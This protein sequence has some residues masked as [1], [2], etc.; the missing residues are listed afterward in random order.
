MKDKKP[1]I[2][3]SEPVREIISN[4]PRRIIRW[5]TTFIFSVLALLLILSWL[6]KYPDVVPATIEITTINPPVTLVS[7]ITGRIN[8]LYVKDEQNVSSGQLLAVMETAASIVEVRQLKSIFDTVQKP[9]ALLAESFPGFYALGELQGHYT[10]FMKVLSDYNTYLRNDFYGSKIS[11]VSEEIAGIQEYIERIKVKEELV[12]QNL[13][14]ERNKF[15]RDSALHSSKV[16]TDSDLEESRQSFIRIKLELQEVR[17]DYSAKAIGL[18]EKNQLL[19]DYRINRQ[20]EKE[21]LVSALSESYFNLKAQMKIWENNYLLVS[22]VDGKVA[23]TRYWSENQSVNIDQAVMS[24]VPEVPGDFIGRINL[25]MQRSGKVKVDQAVNVKLSG[26]P[27]LEFGMVRGKVKSKSIVPSGDAYV[28]E[29]TFPQG[30]T[31]L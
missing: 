18:A 19:Q 3:Y 25:K 1:D 29:I 14:I 26:Y 28:I 12:F 9:E 20:E 23:F 15:E 30:L 10:S 7:K 21:K 31:T 17:L 11:S 27:Y 22:P 4:P 16:F 2:L 5:G 8:K 13:V 6:I 24:V